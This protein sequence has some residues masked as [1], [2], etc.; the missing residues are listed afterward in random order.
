MD[1]LSRVL[2]PEWMGG[3]VG[4]LLVTAFLV[5]VA[6]EAVKLFTGKT[7]PAKCGIVI[8]VPIGILVAWAWAA[9]VT[10]KVSLPTIIKAGLINAA[11]S[12]VAY[13]NIVKPLLAKI[14][15]AKTV[16]E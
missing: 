4:G 1:W 6:I 9:G 8:A 2:N 3:F 13:E 10:E 5:Q 16:T 12:A 11:A 7:L 15:N 14:Q